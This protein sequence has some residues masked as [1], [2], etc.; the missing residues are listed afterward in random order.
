MSGWR[1]RVDD[2]LKGENDRFNRNNSPEN[3]PNDAIVP[4]VPAPLTLRNVWRDGLSDINRF[5][6]RAGFTRQHWRRLCDTGEWWFNHYSKQAALDGWSTG[7]VFGLH[8]DREGWSGLIDRLGNAR[9]LVMEG[10]RARWRSIEGVPD[11]MNA[12]LYAELK[13]FWEVEL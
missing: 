6:P 11:Q 9:N 10:G 13:P 3:R 12:G 8:P 1:E 7:D 4:I 2:A 5:E